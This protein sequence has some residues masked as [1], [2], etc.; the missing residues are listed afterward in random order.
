MHP[1]HRSR[2]GSHSCNENCNQNLLGC[3]ESRRYSVFTRELWGVFR[4]YLIEV[5]SA[6]V[7][8]ALMYLCL[9]PLSCPE[10]GCFRSQYLREIT[11]LVGFQF[12]NPWMC[13]YMKYVRCVTVSMKPNE[14]MGHPQG[15]TGTP[16]LSYRHHGKIMMVRSDL[17]PSCLQRMLCFCQIQLSLSIPT[18]MQVMWF[19]YC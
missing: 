19:R 4:E 12:V 15:D 9:C 14:E 2:Q 1:L 7:R 10:R 16:E 5:G 17:L 13:K 8:K 6:V 11:A 3:K 18:H